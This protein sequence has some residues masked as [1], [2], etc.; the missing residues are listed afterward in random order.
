MPRGGVPV[1]VPVA[2]AL[3]AP[4]DVLVVRKVGVPGHD[5]LAMGAVAES[6][7][8]IV[9]A[10]V[11]RMA[12]V[13]DEQL[14]AAVERARAQ[15][16]ERLARYRGTSPP[17]DVGGRAA[18]VVDDGLATGATARAAVELVRSRGPVA[19]ILGVPVGPPDTCAALREVADAVVC[20]LQPADF[21]AVGQWYRHF[22]QTTDDE[23]VRLL[24]A[25]R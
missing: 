21:V 25:A 1:A 23:V 6:G 22:D 11:V 16:R 24:A 19:V 5:E 12:G 13:S 17:V 2:E 18:V 9:N 14:A 7:P 20:L 8:P 15:V 4:L 10:D 3:D